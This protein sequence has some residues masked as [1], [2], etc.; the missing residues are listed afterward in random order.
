MNKRKELFQKALQPT[1]S[2]ALMIAIGITWF[3][4]SMSAAVGDEHIAGEDSGWTGESIAEEEYAAIEEPAEADISESGTR[5]EQAETQVNAANE[6]EEPQFC[7]VIDSGHGGEDPGALDVTG[8]IFEADVNRAITDEFIQ[9]L[10]ADGRARV[11]E[12]HQPGEN[13]GINERAAI[14]WEN[15]A[16]LF[17]S[18]HLNSG[19]DN[20][21]VRGFMLFPP[22]PW[23]PYHGQSTVAARMISEQMTGIGAIPYEYDGLYYLCFYAGENMAFFPS[24]EYQNGELPVYGPTF[25]VV[26]YANTPALLIEQW[27]ITNAQDM[28]QFNNPAGIQAMAGAL[29]RGTMNYLAGEV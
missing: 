8:T 9:L 19:G 13:P 27:F 14:G 12:T 4:I 7:V 26:E 22:N 20:H 28:E 10:M 1:I 16:D 23:S 6:A 5:E 21:D 11:V 17:L 3:P 2:I 29:Y 18:L 15:N 25:G 24:A